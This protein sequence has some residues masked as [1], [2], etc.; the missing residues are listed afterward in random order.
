MTLLTAREAAARLTISRPTLYNKLKNDPTFPRP[1]YV[2][3][4]APRWRVDELDAWLDRLSAAR[5]A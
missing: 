5:V 2:A 4:S 3:K 1:I